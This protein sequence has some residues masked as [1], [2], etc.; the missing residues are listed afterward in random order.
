MIG[1]SILFSNIERC[2]RGGAFWR[3]GLKNVTVDGNKSIRCYVK[4]GD[5]AKI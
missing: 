3:Q 1:L 5:T 4:Q 2:P